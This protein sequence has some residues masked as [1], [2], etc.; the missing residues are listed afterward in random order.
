MRS[1][2]SGARRWRL[3]TITACLVAAAL[4]LGACGGDD[5]DDVDP[6]DVTAE[7]IAHEVPDGYDGP[8][9]DLPTE[10]P[11]PESCEGF[12]IGW[13]NP[14]AA[15]ENLDAQERAFVA[16]VE[17]LG[18]ET[19]TLDDAVDPDTQV[20]NMQQLLAQD[21]NAI[22]FFPIDPGAIDPVLDEADGAG[23]P[24]LAIERT[25]D[26]DEDPGQIATQIWQGRDMQAFNMVTFLS[27]ERPDAEIAIIGFAVPVPSIEFLVERLEFWSGE[28]GLDVVQMEENPS[29]DVAGG[30]QAMSPIIANN[31]D[32]EGLLAYNDPSGLGAAA[33]ARGAGI[34]DI[35]IVGNNGGEDGLDG[36]RGGRLAA[37][38]QNDAIGI[39]TQG[40]RALCALA[41]DPDADIPPIVVLPPTGAITEDNVDQAQS[42][43]EQL[44]ELEGN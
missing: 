6:N 30:E 31:P 41:D 33:A 19:I 20:S 18:G 34:E 4:V 25:L 27:G 16:E 9:A 11:E 38:F 22:G 13:Q 36:V 39:G 44:R 5:D 37:T 3:S 7:T 43:A 32:I 12:T 26:A 40:A 1:T 28:Q 29:D 15:N 10:Y 21:A 24:V 23:V 42:W 8:E 35:T 17:R 14:L 2:P